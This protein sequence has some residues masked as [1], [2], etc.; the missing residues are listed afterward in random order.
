MLESVKKAFDRNAF[1]EANVHLPVQISTIE[2]YLQILLQSYLTN[3]GMQTNSS[4]IA[5]VIPS[6]IRM[7]YVWE[8]MDLNQDSRLF[9]NYLLQCLKGK[10][11]F[12]LNSP[13]YQVR[14]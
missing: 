9:C 8:Y 5:D 6:V 7:I 2:T 14:F 1:Q 4:S 10:F 3:V 13:I 11:N 12:E